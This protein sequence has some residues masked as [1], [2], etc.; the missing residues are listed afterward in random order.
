M[1]LLYIF[2][3]LQHLNWSAHHSNLCP[4]Y[5]IANCLYSVLHLGQAVYFKPRLYWLIPTMVICGIGEVIG[6]AGRLINSRHPIDDNAFM[7]QYVLSIA[8]RREKI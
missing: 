3:P 8:S 4:C 6:W 2:D 1:D 5:F 7:T